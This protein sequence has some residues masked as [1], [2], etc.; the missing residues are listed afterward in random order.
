MLHTYLC[1]KRSSV[2]QQKQ[3]K[4]IQMS[5][6]SLLFFLMVYLYAFSF[7]M[8][9][10][11]MALLVI[12]LYQP[13]LIRT[14]AFFVR[15]VNTFQSTLFVYKIRPPFEL[16]NIGNYARIFLH[17]LQSGQSYQEFRVVLSRLQSSKIVRVS[18]WRRSIYGHPA[19]GAALCFV[20]SSV[21]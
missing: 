17:V 3:K 18:N 20:V 15:A 14:I 5:Q 16:P 11:K 21:L 9:T 19:T 2:I 7:F 10:A 13:H 6:N 1:K 4:K 12:F 8:I